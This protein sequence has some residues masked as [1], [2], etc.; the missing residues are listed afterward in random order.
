MKRCTKCGVS[1][2]LSEFYNHN[3]TK[4]GLTYQCKECMTA[5]RK[6]NKEHYRLYMKNLRLTK[7]EII[8]EARNKSARNR[9]IQRLFSGA[10]RRAKDKNLEFNIT[11]D[12]IIIPDKCPLL[13]IPFINGIGKNYESTPSL[14][15][16]DPKKG[17][18]K[19]NIWVI[20]KKA[21]SMKNS[22][23]KEELLIFANNIIKYFKDDDIVQS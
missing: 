16:I 2:P 10:K 21:N 7:N 20:T 17:Y 9:P 12:D 23:T 3:T 22:A 6:A 19:G 11:L 15:R 18:I 1:K 5:Y 4:D 14:D 8:K 13:N